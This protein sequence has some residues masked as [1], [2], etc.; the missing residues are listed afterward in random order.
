MVLFATVVMVSQII[1][2][3]IQTG[4]ASQYSEGRMQEVIY[5]RQHGC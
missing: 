4:W 1:T 2:P 3:T 5:A